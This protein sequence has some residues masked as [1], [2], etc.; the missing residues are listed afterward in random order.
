MSLNDIWKL[1]RI[2]LALIAL[3]VMVGLVHLSVDDIA[4]M[5]LIALG[6]MLVSDFKEKF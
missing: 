5:A 6:G 1:V 4:P 2:V 3:L